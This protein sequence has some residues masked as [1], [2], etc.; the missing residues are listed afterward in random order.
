MPELQKAKAL[1][2]FGKSYHAIAKEIGRDDKTIKKHLSKPEVVI[3]V[4]ELTEL[5]AEEY[6]Q[7]NF[8]ILK[9]ITDTDIKAAKLRDRIVS[10]GICTDKSRLIKGQSTANILTGAKIIEDA[11]KEIR[12]KYTQEVM[13]KGEDEEDE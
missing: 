2:A 8:R 10:A 13:I 11:D 7:I 12:K 9:S 1:R 3:E 6:T 4:Q 5:I